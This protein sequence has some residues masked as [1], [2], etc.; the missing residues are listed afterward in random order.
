MGLAASESG[1]TRII[2]P[3]P[4]FGDV[5][6]HLPAA[7]CCP[8]ALLRRA[9]WQVRSYLCRHRDHV[10]FP[11][12]LSNLSSFGRH[13]LGACR[14]IPRGQ[15]ASYRD[16]AVQAGR[17]NASRAVGQVMA[18]NPVPI[19]VPCH[20]VIGS[21]GSLTG[22]GAGLDVKRRLLNLEGAHAAAQPVSH[23]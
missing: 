4:A 10:N 15:T 19:A 11:V 3:Q 13:V 7:S 14:T 1:I 9:Y 5:V 20:R 16:I 8:H 22:F 18:H 2:L 17:P 23:G 12:D 6:S 21:D